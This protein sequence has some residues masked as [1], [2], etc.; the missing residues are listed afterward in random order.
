MRITM[1]AFAAVAVFAC[2]GPA[3]AIPS[4]GN[5]QTAPTPSTDHQVVC[6]TVSAPTGT[7]FGERTV[8]KT[9]NDWLQSQNQGHSDA[10]DTQL[11][12][13][14]ENQFGE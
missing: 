10:N 6:K 5:D 8:C 9:H 13:L 2:A 14:G 12:A 1:V 3:S 4:F 11:R 7:R